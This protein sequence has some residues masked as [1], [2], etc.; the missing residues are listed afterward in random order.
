MNFGLLSAVV[1]FCCANASAQSVIPVSTG[2]ADGFDVFVPISR[3]LGNGDAEK[4]SAWFSNSV[5]ITILGESNTCSCSQARQ[6]LKSFYA[7]Y[8]PRSFDVTHKASQG[9]MKYAIGE[10]KAGACGKLG[11]ADPRKPLPEGRRRDVCGHCLPLYEEQ[12][13]R[14]P[15]IEN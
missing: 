14:H 11:R 1:M 12:L 15:S 13:L 2:N 4:L 3:Y 9:N 6:I 7:A 10:L 8:T 5:E